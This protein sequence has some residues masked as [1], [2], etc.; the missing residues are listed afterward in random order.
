MGVGVGLLQTW[1]PTVALFRLNPC[2]AALTGPAGAG[3]QG[4]RV[5]PPASTSPWMSLELSTASPSTVAGHLALLPPLKLAIRPVS[6]ISDPLA[7]DVPATVEF[8]SKV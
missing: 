8:M 5:P 6:E 7:L 2:A 3:R 1:P 4:L